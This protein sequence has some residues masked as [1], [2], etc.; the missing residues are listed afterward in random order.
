M[1]A[2]S[3]ISRALLQASRKRRARPAVCSSTVAVVKAAISCNSTEWIISSHPFGRPNIAPSVDMIQE[4]KL[5]TALFSAEQGRAGIGQINII[6]KGGGNTFHGS[7]YEFHR[8]AKLAALN[9]FDLSRQQRKAAGLPE[10]PPYIRNQFGFSF[11]GP[12][13]KNKTF[14]FGNYEGTLIR[15][16]A[17]GVLTVPD[18]ALRGGDFSQRATV[19]YDPL[20]LNAA[21]NTRSP[22]PGIAYRQSASIPSPAISSRIFRR[23]TR[24]ESC[25]ITC[26]QSGSATISTSSRHES[27]IRSRN[28]T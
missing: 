12:I 17:R 24:P 2:I 9:F 19:I 3:L 6:S 1:A 16:V 26:R 27:I 5:E 8:N 18:S 22:F 4:F 7:A 25:P 20:T 11:G 13:R 15:Q 23:K 10:T 14:F 28:R 21:T